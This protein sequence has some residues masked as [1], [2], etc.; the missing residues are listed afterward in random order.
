MPRG[1]SDSQQKKSDAQIR[2]E[3]RRDEALEIL[4]AIKPCMELLSEKDA[5][6]V[7][8]CIENNSQ[9]GIHWR[10]SE[11]MLNWLHDIEDKVHK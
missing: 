1:L 10:V 3:T 7:R 5:D 4:E 11:A 2:G 9:Y 8:S 6:F